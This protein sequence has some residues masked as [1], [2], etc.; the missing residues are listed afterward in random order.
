MV[1]FT[2]IVTPTALSNQHVPT[3]AVQ[4]IVDGS[5]VGEPVKLDAKGSARWETARLR[6][7]LH[8]V[9]GRYIPGPGSALLASTSPVNLHTVKRCLCGKGERDK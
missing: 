7:G 8:R 5:K 3:G 1:E 2:A 4:F 6:V 9:V